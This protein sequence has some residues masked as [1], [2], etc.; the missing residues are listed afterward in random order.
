MNS[1]LLSNVI[2][3]GTKSHMNTV[4]LAVQASEDS[5]DVQQKKRRKTKRCEM[6]IDRDT[7]DD[8]R[9]NDEDEN[10]LDIIEDEGIVE[11]DFKEENFLKFE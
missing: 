9:D 5:T 10:T 1:L 3:A 6:P 4:R 7:D 2:G 8:D 11:K